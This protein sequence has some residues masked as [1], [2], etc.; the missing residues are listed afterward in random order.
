[1]KKIIIPTD[2]T[3]ES[4]QLIEYAIL[5]YPD[6]KL[7]I[8]LAFGYKIPLHEIEIIKF[9]AISVIHKTTSE[10]FLRAKKNILIEHSDRLNSIN[11]ELFCGLNSVVFQN[12]LSEHKIQDAI[13]PQNKFLCLKNNKCFDLTSLIKKNV[14]KVIEVELI[15]RSV[16]IRR[17][18]FSLL[19]FLEL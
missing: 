14:K 11:I 6:E 19:G 18:R 15:N 4:L 13:V 3:V 5:N 8:T 12:F 2:F 10:K 1:M 16:E 17:A 7:D 9:S